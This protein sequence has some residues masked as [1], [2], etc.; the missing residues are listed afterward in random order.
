MEML[1]FLE[2]DKEQVMNGL[3]KAGEPEAAQAVLEK[4]LDRLL[5]KYNEECAEERMR[6]SARHM[7]QTAKMMI[8]L[9][10]AAGETR[11]WSKNSSAGGSQ[12]V[13]LTKTAIACI[14]GGILFLVGA[15]AGLALSAGKEIS[16]SAILASIPAAILG[17]GLLFWGGRL[18]LERRSSSSGRDDGSQQVEIRV[19]P[20]RVW[21]CLR[22]LVLSVDKS[23]QEVREAVNYEKS[24]LSASFGNGIS[25]E[26]AELFSSLLEGA[27]S[28][29]QE[30][31]DDAS[32]QEMISHLRYYLHR[33]QV[34]TVDYG[35]GKREW[36]ELLPG[37]QEMTIRPALVKDGVLVKKGLAVARQ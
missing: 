5:L 9:I 28:Q 30:Y 4:E 34:E 37:M 35:G 26:E 24:Q 18:S 6:E 3:V 36:Y 10:S 1:E 7:L 27:Y 15:L 20:D 14:A 25:P 29:M 12:G 16:V 21:A 17:G 11:I 32:V 33:K 19:N 2:S 8:P 23:L 22:A 31:P 13:K